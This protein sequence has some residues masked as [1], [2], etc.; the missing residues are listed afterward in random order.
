MRLLA[1]LVHRRLVSEDD[2]RAAAK[3]KDPRKW[4]VE[5]GIVTDEQW[6]HWQQTDAGERPVLSRYELGELLGEGGSARVYS[7]VD[8]K[9]GTRLCLKVMRPELSKDSAQLGRFVREAR[10]LMALD[11][12]HI[13]RGFRVARE[14]DWCFFAMELLP[15]RCLQDELAECGRIGEE[16]AL[17]IVRDVAD[18]LGC[19]HERGLVHRDVK[20][21]N[22]LWSAERG[23]VLIDLGFAVEGGG[24]EAE[25]TAGT[26]HYI[27]PEQARGAAGLDVRADIYSLGATL[28]HLV[29]GSL[30]FR[31][32]SSE[33]VLA[34]QVREALSGSEIRALGLSPQVHYF[35]EKMMAKEREIRFQDPG[36]LRDE[37]DEYLRQLA[38]RREIE[39]RA[40]PC[41]G[42]RRARG[43]PR[44]RRRRRR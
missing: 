25:T 6:R 8:R 32:G 44:R 5:S 22:I 31:G 1:L 33:E 39:A 35:I 11:H 37:V 36:Q 12:P 14:G 17:S 21:G 29:T 2:A 30:P 26:V 10:L 15:G 13:V 23:A 43:A 28:Y 4:L 34:K 19:L 20:P 40:A 42:G 9:D 38:S 7:A 3:T 41:L 24:G 18:A 16:R 27:A